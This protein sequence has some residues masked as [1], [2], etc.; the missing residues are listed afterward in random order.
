[1]TTL[2]VTPYGPH[3]LTLEQDESVAV[4][5]RPAP[6]LEPVQI[7]ISV[8]EI[9][10]NRRAM[11]IRF[12]SYST[13]TVKEEGKSRHALVVLKDDNKPVKIEI[14]PWELKRWEEWK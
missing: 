9:S 6:D 7:I 13:Y 8:L 2:C 3:F 5:F 12:P 11:H 14:P 10:S 1:M 4:Q